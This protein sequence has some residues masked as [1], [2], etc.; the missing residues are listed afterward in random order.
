MM[1]S[2]AVEDLNLQ[3]VMNPSSA[4]RPALNWDFLPTKF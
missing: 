2:S 1:F 4:H 3:I